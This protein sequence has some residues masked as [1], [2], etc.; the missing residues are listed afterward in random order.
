[1]GLK[2]I[3]N[4]YSAFF[5][6]SAIGNDYGIFTT[7]ERYQQVLDT[8]ASVKKYC[9]NSDI[10]LIDN[11]EQKLPEDYIENLNAMTNVALFLYD[12]PVISSMGKNYRDNDPNRFHKKTLG[13][14]RAVIIATQVI[15]NTNNDYDLVFKLNGRCTLNENFNVKNFL[16]DAIVTKTRDIFCDIPV[17][18]TRLWSFPYEKINSVHEMFKIMYEHTLEL[19]IKEETLQI[20][21]YSFNNFIETYNVPHVQLPIIGLSGTFGFNGGEINE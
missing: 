3:K 1:M 12:D 5:I 6:T 2:N 11:T 8:I 16:H 20:I 21:E 10:Y 14:I 15:T 4:P 7:E 13:E 19:L 9:P 17:I 18:P